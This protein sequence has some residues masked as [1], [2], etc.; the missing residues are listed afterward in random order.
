[1][2]YGEEFNPYMKFFGLWVPNTVAMS[3]IPDS[4][5][6]LLGRL[7]QF[8]GADGKAYPTRKRLC[9]ELGWNKNKLDRAIKN[10]KDL[11]LIKVVQMDPG[12]P[13][14]PNLYSF[15]LHK[16]YE[17]PLI[18]SDN[19]PLS[20]PITPPLS[21]L[22]GHN[23]RVI[24]DE[25]KR[26]SFSKEKEPEGSGHVQYNGLL[27]KICGEKQFET[28]SGSTCKNGHGGVEG[29]TLEEYEKNHKPVLQHLKRIGAKPLKKIEPS[30]LTSFNYSTE[31]K[32]ILKCWEDY[33]GKLH[34]QIN[35]N[36]KG[37]ANI[38]TMIDELLIDGR[39]PY[40]TLTD[41]LTL[42]MRKWSVKEICDCIKYYAGPHGLNKDIESFYFD[43]FIIRRFGG[44][45]A[46]NRKDYS[47]LIEVFKELPKSESKWT[48]LLNDRFTSEF[49]QAIVYPKSIRTIAAFLESKIDDYRINDP[50]HTNSLPKMFLSYMK[51]RVNIAGK[52]DP[53]KY[54]ASSEN[55]DKF[56]NGC[57]KN[58]KAIKRTKEEKKQWLIDKPIFAENRRKAIEKK[59]LR[60]KEFEC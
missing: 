51:E 34:V 29:V 19:T 53:I 20:N 54:M 55:I 3:H 39:N 25:E 49:P 52:Y 12:N 23:R 59:R 24:I 37:A 2:K 22:I 10:L 21:N 1:M 44:F 33:Q 26:E 17:T 41:D 45:K 6:L 7:M 43:S 13:Q 30:A 40:I 35:G 18:K 58:F 28:T 47:P 42:R 60:E 11:Q 14:S 9:K 48:K 8:G 31:A 16:M 46:R 56:W 50:S 15:L 27:C 32:Q 36:G 4:S 5:K 38:Q 57:I